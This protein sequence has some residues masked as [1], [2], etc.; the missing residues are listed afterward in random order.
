[1]I[2]L[3]D[4]R[5]SGNAYKCRLALAQLGM[6]YNRVVYDIAKNETRTPAFLSKTPNG[7]IPALE[8][9]DGR[10]LAESNAILCYLA[11]GTTLL[12]EDG[13]LRAL[14]MQ[15]LFWEQYSHEPNIATV[16]YWITYGIPLNDEMRAALEPKRARGRDALALMDRHLADRAYVVGDTYTIADIALYAYTHVAPEGGFDLT[17]YLAV[18]AWLARVADQPGYIPITA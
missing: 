2:T 16:R 1:M 11:D 14:V 7:K 4:G 10:V 13:W 3:H 5:S 15:W 12:P 6:T 17:P 18:T 8:L 9:E